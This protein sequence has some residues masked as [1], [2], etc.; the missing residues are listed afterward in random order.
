[1][2]EFPKGQSGPEHPQGRSGSDSTTDDSWEII[3]ES[4][5]RLE[6]LVFLWKRSAAS[7]RLGDIHPPD[8]ERRITIHVQQLPQR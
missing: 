1:M 2:P 8:G 6:V 7:R 3:G 4:R 5:V